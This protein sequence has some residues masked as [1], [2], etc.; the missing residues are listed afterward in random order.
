MKKSRRY[1]L[2]TEP[3]SSYLNQLVRHLAPDEWFH[4]QRSYTKGQW[5]QD[6][7]E[8]CFLGL[9]TIW[10]LQVDVHID[11]GD[12]ELSVITCAGSFTGGGLYLP[13]LGLHLRYVMF[14]C[15][16]LETLLPT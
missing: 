8:S 4:L 2:A 11:Q 13:D 16:C 14:F 10:K 6:V 9:A 1:L 15:C 3:Y 7:E 5:Y 12:Y